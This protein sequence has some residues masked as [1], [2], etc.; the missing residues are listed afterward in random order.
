MEFDKSEN[1]KGFEKSKDM[2]IELEGIKAE[3]SKA[4]SEL[5]NKRDEYQ[6]LID[7]MKSFKSKLLSREQVPEKEKWYKRL[8]KKR[9]EVR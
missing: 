4:I 3:F 9:N 7:E 1:S 5:H 6:K 2:I 8:F